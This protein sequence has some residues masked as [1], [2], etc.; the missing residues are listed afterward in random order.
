MYEEPV[1]ESPADID[2]QA[3]EQAVSGDERFHN[4]LM[5][6]PDFVDLQDAYA[7]WVVRGYYIRVG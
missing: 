2:R 7:E 1:I 6:R 3:R 5:A 4:W